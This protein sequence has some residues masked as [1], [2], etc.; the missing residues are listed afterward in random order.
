MR[1]GPPRPPGRPAPAGRTVPSAAPR[2]PPG[3]S[4]L[5]LRL[6]AAL[7]MASLLSAALVPG[8]A[9][10]AG[11]LTVASDAYCTF[12]SFC[13]YSGPNFNGQKVEYTRDEL[14]CQNSRPALDVRTVLPGGARS[15]VNNTRVN[16]TGLGVKI[17]SAADHL[18]L[19]SVDPGRQVRDLTGTVARQ[20]QS[21]CAYPI[22]GTGGTP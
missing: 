9:M 15:L 22:Q 4:N 13:L 7:G 19:T 17:Y 8:A 1:S 12:G 20:M 3:L 11:A 6:R 10:A 14:F 2:L 18:V 16:V 5:S 21:L